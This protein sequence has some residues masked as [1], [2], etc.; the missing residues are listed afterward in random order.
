MSEPSSA[1]VILIATPH[2]RYDRLEQRARELLPD[3]RIV[4][5]RT[6]EELLPERLRQLQPQFVF[7]P[8]WSW[9]IPEETYLGFECVIFHMTD[10]PY[11]RGGSPLQNLIVRGHRETMLSALKC[12]RELDAGPIFLKR[13]LPLTGTAEEIFQRAALLM[14]EMLVEI[15][16]RKPV[17][18]PQ[19]GE[20]VAFVRRVAADGNIA[21][22]KT[23]EQIYDF[24]R[25]L[26]ADGYPPSFLDI[27]DLHLEFTAARLE[28]DA[29][30]ARVRIRKK[31]SD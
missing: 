21:L 30:E 31:Q 7:F 3:Y 25:M 1:P 20:P 17:P 23:T 15:V 6:R 10:L 28:A 11:G 19:Q 18:E 2:T 5:L 12:V 22:A 9:R 24:I 16:R 14:E 8:H 13:P 26:D 4:R 29:V 27:G